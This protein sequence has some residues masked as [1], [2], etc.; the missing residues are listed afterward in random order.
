LRHTSKSVRP[1]QRTTLATAAFEQLIANVVNGTWKA[2]DRLPAER[3]LC[4]QFGIARTSLR[5]ALKA[6]EL[7]GMLNSRVGDGT[8]VCPRSEF[9]SRPMMWAFTGMDKTELKDVMEARLVIEEGLAGLAAERATAA[10]VDDINKAVQAMSDCIARNESILDADM[11]FHI[12]VSNAA[13]N[14]LLSNS[15]QMLRNLMRQGI[16]FKLLLPGV[17]PTILKDHVAIYHA[18]KR[19]S[20]TAAR[21]AMR[22]HLIETMKLINLAIK[23][24]ER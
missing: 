19:H 24:H 11:A 13:G 21:K 8:F 9:L 18:I 16:Q 14:L 17:S 5:E 7:V 4:R 23:K 22:H 15:L 12:A 2:G 1:I 6:M 3:D 10:Q 20:A